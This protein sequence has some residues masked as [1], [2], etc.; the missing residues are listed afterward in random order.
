MYSLW[1]FCDHG[2]AIHGFTADNV[3]KE[4]DAYFEAQIE[5]PRHGNYIRSYV[6]AGSSRSSTLHT[7][8]TSVPELTLDLEITWLEADN[9]NDLV[10]RFE[11][12]AP[13]I[14]CPD[15]N[16]YPA[17]SVYFLPP[18][19]SDPNEAQSPEE[20]NDMPFWR[21]E[22]PT[23]YETAEDNA[24]NTFPDGAQTILI[25][26]GDVAADQ[27]SGAPLGRALRAPILLQPSSYEN[28]L[29]PSI[30]RAVE[31]LGARQVVILGGNAAVSRGTQDLLERSG[32]RVA[33][34]AGTTR[35]ETAVSI[36][37]ELI[38]ASGAFASGVSLADGGNFTDAITA[39]GASDED[40]L[41][42]TYG[43]E[44]NQLPAE[45]L[46]FL[47]HFEST[48]ENVR[49]VGRAAAN[50]SEQAATAAIAE[51][52]VI[53]RARPFETSIATAQANLAE[54]GGMVQRILVASADEFPDALSAGVSV[55]STSGDILIVASDSDMDNMQALIDFLKLYGNPD[56]QVVAVG[57]TSA[58]SDALATAIADNV[59]ASAPSS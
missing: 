34:I 31:N 13:A 26:N 59:A 12:Q 30:V 28:E 20:L 2:Y 44:S 22:G 5:H 38:S 33:R 3:S 56:A 36:A 10:R 15:D 48:I 1:T 53:V 23:R 47:Q 58:V 49:A 21:I 24:Y 35:Y 14:S 16:T 57:G 7:N 25:A 29:H 19:A 51:S 50:V 32:L 42:L 45:V 39:A 52:E 8:S 17:Q 40:P 27:L 4:Y 54:N 18:G 41:L 46:E 55:D 37:W 9:G 6:P 11:M 43:A